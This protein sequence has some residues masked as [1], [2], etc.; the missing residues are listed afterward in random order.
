[1]P[2]RT[3]L[4]SS[5]DGLPSIFPVP[6]QRPVE[7]S[8]MP[9]PRT[10][11]V[12][13]EPEFELVLAL[14]RRDDVRLVTLTEPGGVGK[15]RIAIRAASSAP[16]SAQFVDLEDVQQPALVLP[17]IA[18]ALGVRPDGRSVLGNLRAVLRHGDYL[19]VL[20]NLEQVL[21]AA[22]TL[23]NLLD[24][25]PNVK[26]LATS[27][28]VL[29]V[30]GQHVV[31]IRPLPLPPVGSPGSETDAL[32]FDAC[33]LFVD[34]A[35]AGVVVSRCRHLA[36]IG[37]DQQR[38]CQRAPTAGAR[39]RFPDPKRPTNMSSQPRLWKGSCCS[40][41]VCGLAGRGGQ[42]REHQ[43]PLG[44]GRLPDR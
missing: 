32:G 4:E 28:A 3:S 2:R 13:R 9:V 22:S 42:G 12:G 21:P 38:S 44:E 31:D 15:T 11:F 39:H 29:G 26:L 40:G 20:D 37:R 5:R 36:I 34:R 8:E 10:S 33:R 23:A 6:N 30:P 24:A 16:H 7:T 18:A 14:L 41:P 35:Q 1:M 17:T 25:C 27:R 43:R 19:L